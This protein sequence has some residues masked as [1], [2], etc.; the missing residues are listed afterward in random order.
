MDQKIQ[1]L[2]FEGDIFFARDPVL[3]QKVLV[4]KIEEKFKGA[5]SGR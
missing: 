5:N 3:D 4:L 1:V 2:M